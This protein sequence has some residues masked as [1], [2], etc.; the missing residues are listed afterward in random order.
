MRRIVEEMRGNAKCECAYMN[1]SKAMSGAGKK[2]LLL[3]WQR[4]YHDHETDSPRGRFN[5]CTAGL[6]TSLIS[7]NAGNLTA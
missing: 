3:T 2:Q 7:S 6:L 4:K 5:P 1:V